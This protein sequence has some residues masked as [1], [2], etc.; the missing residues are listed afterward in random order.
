MFRSKYPIEPTGKLREQ[1]TGLCDPHG[2][3]ASG[4]AESASGEHKK[5]G[6]ASVS[7]AD[8]ADLCHVRGGGMMV[9][10]AHGFGAGMFSA[11]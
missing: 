4:F 9:K 1:I 3:D 6:V 10:I 7:E 11:G 5:V 2:K 8:P